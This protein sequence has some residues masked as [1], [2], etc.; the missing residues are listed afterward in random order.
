[1]RPDLEENGDRASST[2][3]LVEVLDPLL[4]RA[5]LVLFRLDRRG[6]LVS[7]KGPV[8]RLFGFSPE[9][10]LALDPDAYFADGGLD[11]VRNEIRR[12]LR[13]EAEF[14]AYLVE[15][16]A[17]DGRRIPV[18]V[19]SIPVVQGDEVVGVEGL[20]QAVDQAVPAEPAVTPLTR[21]Q[22][23]VLRLLAEG[24]RP[25]EI[26]TRLGMSEPTARNHVRAIFRTL[27]ARSQLEAVLKAIK[28][29]LVDLDA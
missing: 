22:H 10:W 4:S 2:G 7:F 11:K 16:R 24:M 23:E 26:A 28:L 1:M 13:G 25:K 3:A 15:M 5:G 14:S 9:E 18:K 20:I 19:T 12:K 6:A 21:R 29:Q 27:G 17:K 8:E